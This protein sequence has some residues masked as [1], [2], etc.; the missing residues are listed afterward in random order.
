MSWYT[1]EKKNLIKDIKDSQPAV[2]PPNASV[3]PL[4]EI[5]ASMDLFTP[6]DYV[7]L[8][9]SIMIFGLMSVP[10]II[11]KFRTNYGKG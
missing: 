1:D 5:Y 10:F 3:G 2:A 4:A 11:H 7:V 9:Y 6:S 8:I